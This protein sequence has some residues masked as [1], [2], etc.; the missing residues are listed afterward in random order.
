MVFFPPCRYFDLPKQTVRFSAAETRFFLFLESSKATIISQS[1][2]VKVGWI[3]DLCVESV[4]LPTKNVSFNIHLKWHFLVLNVFLYALSIWVS[5]PY[6]NSAIPR[7]PEPSKNN[8]L[9]EVPQQISGKPRTRNQIFQLLLKEFSWS[10]HAL[11]STEESLKVFHYSLWHTW[12][13]SKGL[14]ALMDSDL[15]N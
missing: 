10:F 2:D 13:F 11:E 14:P 3:I 9:S 1:V 15:A 6:G 12:M 8:D 7:E 4:I 5:S